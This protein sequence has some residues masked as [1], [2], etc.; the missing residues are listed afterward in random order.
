VKPSEFYTG[1]VADMYDALVSYRAPAAFYAGLGSRS[2][3][4]PM[5]RK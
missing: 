4:L 2:L 5:P 3:A 1:L